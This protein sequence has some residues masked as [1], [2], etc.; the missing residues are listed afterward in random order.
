[1]LEKKTSIFF[2]RH[3]TKAWFWGDER[4]LVNQGQDVVL[5]RKI[6]QLQRQN[7]PQSL[8]NWKKIA[9]GNNSGEFETFKPNCEHFMSASVCMFVSILSA[10][11][12]KTY[13]SQ[14]EC[15]AGDDKRGW[16]W[17]EASHDLRCNSPAWVVCACAC[18]RPCW[19]MLPQRFN[20]GGCL[21][22]SS[23]LRHTGSPTVRV[24]VWMRSVPWWAQLQERRQWN[25][26]TGDWRADRSSYCVH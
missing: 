21:L 24:W 4:N 25:K 6:Q 20:E 9:V 1:M 11:C 15:N 16:D 5:P 13:G 18:V 10:A 8:I 23:P 17:C 7:K 2:Y 14:L 19:A 3:L 26:W 22:L 12:L